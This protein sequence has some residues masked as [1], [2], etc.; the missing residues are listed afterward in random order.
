MHLSECLTLRRDDVKE[1]HE[2]YYR[3]RV[4]ETNNEEERIVFLTGTSVS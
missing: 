4:T 3:I 1:E 2:G